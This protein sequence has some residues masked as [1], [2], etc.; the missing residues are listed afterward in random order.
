MEKDD[1]NKINRL[2]GKNLKVVRELTG[3]T[4]ASLGLRAFNIPNTRKGRNKA[5]QI[6]SKIE[7]GYREAGFA[8][9]KCISKILRVRAADFLS[10]PFPESILSLIAKRHR[11]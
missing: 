3:I 2:I 9:I 8:E 6:V 10:D 4:Q 7:T 5:Q 1:K 11:K